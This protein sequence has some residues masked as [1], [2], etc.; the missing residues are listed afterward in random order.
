MDLCGFKL[1]FMFVA[2][3]QKAKKIVIGQP[4]RV[5][6]VGCLRVGIRAKSDKP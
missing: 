5:V 1:Q 2:K 4:R 6:A 3:R